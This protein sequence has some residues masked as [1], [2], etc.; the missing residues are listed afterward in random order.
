MV[1]NSW[2]AAVFNG[3]PRR[4]S[5]GLK[6]AVFDKMLIIPKGEM[7]S[8]HLVGEKE[9]M[10]EEGDKEFDVA[11]N[12]GDFMIYTGSAT[13]KAFEQRLMNADFYGEITYRVDTKVTPPPIVSPTMP[14]T[15]APS[16]SPPSSKRP[17]LPSGGGGGVVKKYTTPG[18]NKAGDNAKGVM[19]QIIAR[20][21]ISIT[22]LDIMGKDAKES[23]VSIYYQDGSYN[24]FDALDKGKWNEVFKGKV[25][26]D[27]DELVNIE[28]DE[29]ITIPAGGTASLYV[30]SKK[31]VLFTKSSDKEFDIYGA[32]DEDFFVQVGTSTKKD[33]EQPDKLAEFAGRIV[34]EI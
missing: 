29:D 17:T 16:T 3:I 22:G 1:K 4:T 28:L 12:A 30:V 23:D 19:F 21:K 15:P 32:S 8:I 7:A 18:V 27:P 9:F 10:F 24:K 33:F 6:E 5:G 13:K 2:G 25:M 14:P 11:A 34:Y 26:L 31:G 20:S